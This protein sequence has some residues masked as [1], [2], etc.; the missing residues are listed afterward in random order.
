MV[1]RA[2]GLTHRPDLLIRP[3]ATKVHQNMTADERFTNLAGAISVHPK[4]AD[5]IKDRPVL[6]IDDV[7]TSGATLGACAEACKNAGAKEV[8]IA[9][10]ARVVKDA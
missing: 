3:R 6:M 2:L 1:A 7:M 9:T 4:A 10:L 8:F 5:L